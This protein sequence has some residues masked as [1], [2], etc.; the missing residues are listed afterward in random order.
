ME[1]DISCDSAFMRRKMPEIGAAIRQT[2]PWI[3]Q[4]QPIYLVMDN[5]GGHGTTEA[6]VEYTELL[7]RQF[8]IIIHHQS[9]RSPETNALD[10]G[11]WRSLQAEVEKL[12]HDK[13]T[14]NGAESVLQAWTD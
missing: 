14:N 1:E 7:L 6:I 13:Q 11:L 3:P 9:P 10:L 8:N 4:V 2:M 12:H 5:A